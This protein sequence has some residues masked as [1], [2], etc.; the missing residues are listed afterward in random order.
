MASCIVDY[1][2][3]LLEPWDNKV[4]GILVALRAVHHIPS[5]PTSRLLE[6]QVVWSIECC[7][8]IY[9]PFVD[10][11]LQ[12]PAS[13]DLRNSWYCT[14]RRTCHSVLYVYRSIESPNLH[15]A[16]SPAYYVPMQS[17]SIHMIEPLWLIPTAGVAQSPTSRVP[18]KYRRMSCMFNL[19]T[20]H[21][22]LHT[23][24]KCIYVFGTRSSTY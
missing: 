3:F 2:V 10:F 1:L 7:Y 22:Y 8:V 13:I 15:N 11:S 16:T 17:N 20:C 21:T 6:C 14:H 9:V 5:T 19:G 12:S 18:L 4:T 23:S 24:H